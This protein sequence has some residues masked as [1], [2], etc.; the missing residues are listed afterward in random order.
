VSINQF[1]GRNR[2]NQFPNLVDR[3]FWLAW[4]WIRAASS[5]VCGG[6]LGRSL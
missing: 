3:R 1:L 5:P 4:L 2:A 6:A